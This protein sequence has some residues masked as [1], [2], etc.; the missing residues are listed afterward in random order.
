MYNFSPA[1]IAEINEFGEAE[2]WANYFQCAPADFI[3]KYRLD[4]MGIAYARP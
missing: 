2:A 3:Q 4:A 1:R